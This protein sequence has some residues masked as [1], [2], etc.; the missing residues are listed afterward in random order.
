MSKASKASK[1]S[2]S[3]DLSMSGDADPMNRFPV[4]V[5][6][7]D[8]QPFWDGVAR[9]ELLVQR[10]DACRAWVW[11]PRPLCHRCQQLDPVWTVVTGDGA[12]ASWIVLRPPVLPAYSEMVPFVV[13]LVE[14]EEGVR[15]LGYLVDDNGG[16]AKTDGIE[17]GIAIGSRVAL[18]FHDQAGTKLPCWTLARP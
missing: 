10:C 14:L 15:M 17:E 18:R 13:L 3:G 6:D 5:P 12:V 8:T 9:G 1:A 4:P 7:A 2:K 16:L 11:Q